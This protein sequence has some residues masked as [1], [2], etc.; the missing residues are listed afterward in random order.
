[1]HTDEMSAPASSRAFSIKHKFCLTCEVNRRLSTLNVDH[2]TF[3]LFAQRPAP[4]SVAR[5]VMAQSRGKESR[6]RGSGW[7]GVFEGGKRIFTVE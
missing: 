2:V 1:M 7:L 4:N 6:F 5:E 3:V